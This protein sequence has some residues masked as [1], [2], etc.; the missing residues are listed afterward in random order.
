MTDTVQPPFPAPVLRAGDQAVID[1]LRVDEALGIGELAAALRVTATAVRQ[2]LERLM[3]QGFVERSARNGRRGRPAHVYRLTVSGSRLGGDNFRDLAVVLWREV[4]GIRS[5]EVRRGLLGRIGGSLA[6][7]HRDQ[8][9][10]TTPRERLG[11]VAEIMRRRDIACVVEEPAASSAGVSPGGLAMLTSYACP[12]P[13]IAEHDR[14]ICAA[15]RSMIE[16]VVR[17]PV[18]LAECRLDGGSCCRFAVTDIDLPPVPEDDSGVPAETPAARTPDH[19]PRP[20]VAAS[21][22]TENAPETSR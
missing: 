19:S 14:G 22:Q 21:N 3:R 5:P 10:G 13:D 15:E 1:L 4:R 2:R 17:R 20:V 12:Y 6:G 16:E 8:V 7:L 9:R 18:R 11:E